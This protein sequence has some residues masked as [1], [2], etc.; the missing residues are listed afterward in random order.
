M[1]GGSAAGS[2]GR[3]GFVE[4]HGLWDDAQRAA[5]AEMLRR[6]EADGIE[7]VRFSFPDQHGILR[8]KAIMSG[9][10]AGALAGGVSMTSTLLVKDTAHKTVP[11]V[12]RPGAG[13][14]MPE[15]TGA[16]DFLMVADPA[17]FRVLPWAPRTGWVLCDIRWPDGRAV[18][19]ST[20]DVC[21]S[22]L[23]RLAGMGYDYVAGIEVE[24]H[25]F[26]L[27]DRRMEAAGATQPA[28]PPDVSLLTHGYQYLTEIRLDELDPVL[29]ILRR[30]LAA[31]DLAPRSLEVE[32]G[33]SQIEVTFQPRAGLGS[34]D[35]MV[36]FRNAA[37]QVCA[38]HGYHATFMC[39]PQIENVFAS[40]WHLHQSLRDRETGRPVFMPE[41]DDGEDALLSTPGRR[42]AAGILDHARAASVFT[43]PTINGY[44][45]FRAFSLAPDRAAWARDN[46]GAMLRIIGGAGEPGTR[47]ENRVG[48]PAANP[49]LYLASQIVSGIDGM[50]RMS[51]PG[52]ATETPYDVD[53]PALPASLIEAVA[54]LRDDEAFA[55]ALGREFIDYICMIK[56]A[57]IARYLSEV[58]DWE[59]REYFRIF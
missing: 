23:D 30:A 32:F 45:R 19:F 25:V 31:L 1:T 15:L 2:S 4:R 42:F 9:E 40:G 47:I 43:T 16:A 6:I 21:R 36:L 49:Y 56:E 18:P 53:A 22:A 39:R 13:I 52:P 59:Q 41:A 26:R 44:K 55:G 58:T 38:R 54:A 14:G 29:A 17:T 27:E 46:R 48:E 50:E 10:V 12:F 37:K 3:T 35:A 51:E 7:V 11:P 28:V 8:G 20:R 57:E 24:F 34:A 5:A 33:P